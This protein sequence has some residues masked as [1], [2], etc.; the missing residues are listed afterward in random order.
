VIKADTEDGEF[1]YKK[2]H[3]AGYASLKEC[4]TS[5]KG[6]VGRVGNKIW[7]LQILFLAPRI[8]IRVDRSMAI[9]AGWNRRA[10]AQP[11]RRF[12]T[13]W[14]PKLLVSGVIRRPKFRDIRDIGNKRSDSYEFGHLHPTALLSHA[15]LHKP[16]NFS[17]PRDPRASKCCTTL[18]RQSQPSLNLQMPK[19]LQSS[20]IK[21]L[22][23]NRLEAV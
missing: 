10:P 2:G 4:E 18:V 12:E 15:T 9:S 14:K 5:R 6:D 1:E 22:G 21:A 17:R 13:G 19:V 7:K 23:R 11:I 3:L 16:V 8:R 20:E